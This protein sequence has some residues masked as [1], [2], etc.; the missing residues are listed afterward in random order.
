MGTPA[1]SN[2]KKIAGFFT[3]LVKAVAGVATLFAVALLCIKINSS[4]QPS[5]SAPL[6]E[7]QPTLVRLSVDTLNTFTLIPEHQLND[8]H[9]EVTPVTLRTFKNTQ[10]VKKIKRNKAPDQARLVI[11]YPNSRIQRQTM[12]IFKGISLPSNCERVAL[13]SRGY[14]PLSSPRTQTPRRGGGV[15]WVNRLVQNNILDD[16]VWIT[17]DYNDE[18]GNFGQDADTHM[19]A[20]I[21][22][23]INTACPK[24]KIVVLG[25]CRGAHVALRYLAYRDN[26]S[27]DTLI[28]ESPYGSAEELFNTV[29]G[30]YLQPYIGSRYSQALLNRFVR[31]HFPHYNPQQDNLLGHID[32][33]RNKNIFI[34]HHMHD[35]VIS[36][37]NVLTLVEH[38]RRNN[39]VY[40][41]ASAS[42]MGD[43]SRLSL[44]PSYQKAVNAFLKMCNLP[45]N[46][47]LAHQGMQFLEKSKRNGS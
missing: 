11:T 36:D 12:R 31:W 7:I 24:A 37:K 40:L 22:D 16:A 14:I 45:H 5:L 32:T 3:S 42:N 6:V 9:D 41:F 10:L 34:G 17:F 35:R 38:L 18:H 4:E 25:D 1:M 20:E 39:H 46:A 33:I 47:E 15:H 30:S 29:S 19:F 13:F 27:I 28:L 21:I 44:I 2:I 26:P 23:A 8:I 43:H